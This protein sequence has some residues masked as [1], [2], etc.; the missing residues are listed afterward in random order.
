MSFDVRQY[1]SSKSAILETDVLFHI[2]YIT[3][4]SKS[5][6]NQLEDWNEFNDPNTVSVDR[7]TNSTRTGHVL[8]REITDENTPTV[9]LDKYKLLLR[10]QNNNYSYAYE[11][12]P[13]AFLRD[14]SYH[15]SPMPLKLGGRLLLKKGTSIQSG[16]LLIN[17]NDCRYLGLNPMDTDLISQLNDGLIKKNIELLNKQL[18]DD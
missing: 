18:D 14:A 7:I 16:S 4:I 6:L 2:V 13:L 1:Q 12:Q 15:E 9:T 17:N 8:I 3:N 10:D 5:I 11:N